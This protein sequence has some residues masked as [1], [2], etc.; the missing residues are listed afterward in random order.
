M[1]KGITQEQ[2]SQA[3]DAI[4]AAGE[5]PT[6]EKI[7]QALGTG[8]PNTVTRMLESWRVALAQRL[9]E[10]ITLPEVPP[11]AGQAFAEVWRLAVA[12]ADTFAHL[13]L[14]EER[15]ALFAD[16]TSLAQERKL[17]E[18]ALAEAR[19]NVAENTTK[20]VQIEAQ[21]RERQ[22]LVVQLEAQCADLLEQRNRLQ[23]QLD[24]Q[25]VELASLHAER[26]AT[27]EHLR[28]VEDR[29]HR[30]VDHARQEIKA[31]QQ[32]VQREQREYDKRI[33][34][35]TAQQEELRA[36]V[37][38]AEQQ[39]AHHAGQVVAMEANL[40]RWRSQAAASKRAG[41]KPASTA[42]AKPRHR[43]RKAIK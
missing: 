23:H 29:A 1:R 3:A 35:L 33:T 41:S 21:A 24:L 8:S 31:L 25:N 5:N 32:R 19:A 38:T 9:Q 16:Q 12:H 18:I 34:Q 20:L 14:T 42:K 11:E 37:R 30:Q 40:N 22:A 15:N 26:G 10:V 39:A 7:R 36:T 13:A 2:V 6:V 4:V 27:H 28:L 43:A 17:W